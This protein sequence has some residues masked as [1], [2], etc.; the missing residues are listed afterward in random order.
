MGSGSSNAVLMCVLLHV[1]RSSG[2]PLQVGSCSK[3]RL[4]AVEGTGLLDVFGGVAGAR[5]ALNQGICHVLR[6]LC[7]CSAL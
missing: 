6:A 7:L 1:R 3:Q 2:I 5:H 4:V